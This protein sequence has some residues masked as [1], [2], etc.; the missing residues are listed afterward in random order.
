[1]KRTRD[2]KFPVQIR[3]GEGRRPS[4]ALVAPDEAVAAERVAAM[5]EI[6]RVLVATGRLIEAPQSLALLAAAGDDFEGVADGIRRVCSEPKPADKPKGYAGMTFLEFGTEWTSGRLFKRFRGMHK[7]RAKKPKPAADDQRRIEFVASVVGPVLIKDFSIDHFEAVMAAI[8]DTADS[9]SSRRAFAQVMS[10]L[11]KRAVCLRIRSDF[12]LAE[13]S[14]PQVTQHRE[15]QLVYPREDAQLMACADVDLFDRAYYGFSVRNGCRKQNF[16]DLRWQDIDFVDGQVW[17]PDSKTGK[18]MAFDLA[19]GCVR[20]LRAL[21]RIADERWA[22]AEDKPGTKVPE[23]ATIFPQWHPDTIAKRFRNDLKLALGDSAR[24]QLFEASAHQRVVEFHDLRA[25]FITFALA[26]GKSEEW[27]RERSGHTTSQMIARY[28]RPRVAKLAMRDWLPLDQALGLTAPAAHATPADTAPEAEPKDDEAQG[29]VD[30]QAHL[31]APARSARPQLDDGRDR[32]VAVALGDKPAELAGELQLAGLDG[33]VEQAPQVGDRE[34][35]L[36]H[37]SDPRSTPAM[38]AGNPANATPEW[39]AMGVATA[40]GGQDSEDGGNS[41][42]LAL[43]GGAPGGTRTPDQQ[44]RNQ[45][46]T[47]LRA[48]EHDTNKASCARTNANARDAAEALP[49]SVLTE[50]DYARLAALALAANEW[51][52]LSRVARDRALLEA[53][54]VTQSNVTPLL[55]ER[56]KRG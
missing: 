51:E 34:A 6:A 54:R 44:I 19:P 45:P 26:N 31:P 38:T 16:L 20:A 50:A 15:F 14:L 36:G 2:G 29:H 13:G 23:S 39:V 40:P 30:E 47:A 52:L 22:R 11:L 53:S 18:P 56:R 28:R 42:K 35:A 7:I 1:M 48:H 41:M 32:A 10:W 49:I 33:Q 37:G 25:S 9:D 3:I 12:P 24:A 8:P 4:F 55:V 17:V 27:I 46:G 21:K 43:S 5:T